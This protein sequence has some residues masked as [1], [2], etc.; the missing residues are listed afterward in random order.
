MSLMLASVKMYIYYDRIEWLSK[1]MRNHTSMTRQR[2][3]AGRNFEFLGKFC[4]W[5]MKIL[6]CSIEQKTQKSCS[7]QKNFIQKGQIEQKN[8]VL[9]YY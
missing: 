7:T 1:V 6:F 4:V 8:G 5:D 3:S 9:S 2:Y